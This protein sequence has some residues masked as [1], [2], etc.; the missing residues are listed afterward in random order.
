[1]IV[2]NSAW[3]FLFVHISIA[4]YMLASRIVVDAV[5]EI[6]IHVLFS[7]FRTPRSRD[8]IQCY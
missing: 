8:W 3:I 6:A 1:M 4:I 5:T 2:I 7:L